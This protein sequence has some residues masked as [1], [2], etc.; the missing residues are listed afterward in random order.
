[1]V[2]LRLPYALCSMLYATGALTPIAL[3][4]FSF[5]MFLK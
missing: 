5:G 4:S 3:T 2:H 1:M